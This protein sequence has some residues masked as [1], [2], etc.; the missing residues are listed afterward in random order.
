MKER[1]GWI[2]G[3]LAAV[4]LTASGC[5]SS[6]EVRELS[7]GMTAREETSPSG[8]KRMIA[9]SA[10]MDLYHNDPEEAVKKAVVSAKT[11]GGWVVRSD[12]QSAELRVPDAKLELVMKEIADIGDVD[13]KEIVGVDVTEQYFDVQL[14]LENLENIRKR[15][16]E[17][18]GKANAVGEALPVE[19]ELERVTLEIEMLKGR[20]QFL[21]SSVSFASLRVSFRREIW[22]GPIGWIFYGLYYGIKWLF[23]WD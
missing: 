20:Q 17:L 22:P 3:W 2:A 18:L 1:S 16:T 9:R 15:Y 8:E 7:P 5:A 21:K 12:N 4:A 14:R 13:E 23:V 6:A 10:R 11:A 19:K